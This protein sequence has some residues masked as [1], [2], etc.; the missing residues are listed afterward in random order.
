MN[1]LRP[2][3]VVLRSH[4]KGLTQKCFLKHKS[5]E[6]K[7]EELQEKIKMKT[8]IGNVDCRVMLYTNYGLEC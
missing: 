7:K 8:P 2:V 1:L 4:V 6:A 5:T 3:P